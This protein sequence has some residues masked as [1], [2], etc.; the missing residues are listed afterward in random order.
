MD[1][2]KEDGVL[3]FIGNVNFLK[4]NPFGEDYGEDD[5]AYEVPDYHRPRFE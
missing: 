1:I 2:C 3:D 5:Y 4:T